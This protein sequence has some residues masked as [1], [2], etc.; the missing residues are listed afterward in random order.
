MGADPRRLTVLL[1]IKTSFGGE[2]SVR[3]V[4]DPVAPAAPAP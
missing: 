3:R 1:E 4:F 2:V